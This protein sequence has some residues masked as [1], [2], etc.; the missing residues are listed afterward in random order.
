MLTIRIDL[1]LQMM[2]QNLAQ[3][4]QKNIDMWAHKE[5]QHRHQ[6]ED[7]ER[8]AKN[9]QVQQQG[10]SHCVSHLSVLGILARIGPRFPM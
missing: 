5:M 6:L 3:A 10:D 2:S 1:S 7:L 8:E 9:V 4:S